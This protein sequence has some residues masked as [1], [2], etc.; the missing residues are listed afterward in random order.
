MAPH[1]VTCSGLLR[2]SAKGYDPSFKVPHLEQGAAQ[3]QLEDLE[4][5]GLNWDG[6]VVR[7]S[8]RGADHEAAIGSLTAQVGQ[9]ALVVWEKLFHE[10]CQARWEADAARPRIEMDGGSK[11]DW[12]PELNARNLTP[13]ADYV[14]NGYTYR[15]DAQ[16]RVADVE[17]QL[18]LHTADRNS[19]EQ[20]TAFVTI[21]NRTGYF[22]YELITIA[23][24]LKNRRDYE[25]KFQDRRNFDDVSV[26]VRGLVGF[27]EFGPQL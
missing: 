6:E 1:L 7:Q 2:R 20:R 26:F 17:G 19:Y 18:D 11:G 27:T 4:A 14:V 24:V 23:G 10:V 8:E 16:G 12:S 9:F 15:T 13:N 22:G 5:L 3:R 25:T 21:T